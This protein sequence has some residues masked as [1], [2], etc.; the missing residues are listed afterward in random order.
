MK[1]FLIASLLFTTALFAQSA[2]NAGLSFLK[3]GFGARNMAMSDLGVV[4]ANDVTALNYNPALIA[5]YNGPEIVVTHNEWIQDVRSEMIGVSFEMF[6]L[7]FAFGANTT[8]INDIEVRTKPGESE[9]S[10]DANYFYGSLST[11]FNLVERINVGITAK[12]L[13]EG[14]LSDEANGWAFD[15]G[16]TYDDLIE[17]LNIGAS[18]RNIGSMNELRTEETQ[19]PTDLRI[20]ASYEMPLESIEAQLL[21]LGG[22]QQYTDTDDSHIHGGFELLYKKLVAI[23]G[24]YMSGYESKGLTA[25]FGVR[26]ST[27]SFDYAFIPFDYNLGNSHT[28]SVMYSFN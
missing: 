5:K 2:G 28:I 27:I 13:Y 23:R 14:L 26:W 3:I 1:K 8:S 15:F 4:T 21:L 22:I 18:L 7:P 12:Y 11:G 16:V 20:G 24:G 25:G 6:G 19:L 9:S 17:N 10:F